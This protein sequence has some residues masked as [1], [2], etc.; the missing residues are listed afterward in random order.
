MTFAV[1]A[2]AAQK[3]LLSGNSERSHP[4]HGS[5]VSVQLTFRCGS[6]CHVRVR[7]GARWRPS[8]RPSDSAGYTIA[9][10]CVRA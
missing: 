6:A 8:T 1:E 7:P 10:P 9:D 4:P 3:D 5:K 2:W